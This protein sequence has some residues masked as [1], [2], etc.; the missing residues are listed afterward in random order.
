MLKCAAA[1]MKSTLLSVSLTCLGVLRGDLAVNCS[2]RVCQAN[3]SKSLDFLSNSY[4]AYL[5]FPTI[6]AE[7][8]STVGLK[9]DFSSFSNLCHYKSNAI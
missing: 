4:K 1:D 9:Q 6:W 5:L 7:V 2:K 8:S 3:R